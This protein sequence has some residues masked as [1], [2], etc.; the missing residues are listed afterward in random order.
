ME[1][2]ATNLINN[3]KKEALHKAKLQD[4]RT[5]NIDSYK[6]S[7]N[8]GRFYNAEEMM[9]IGTSNALIQVP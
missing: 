7:C 5:M 4:L 3:W 2:L 8:G 6:F 1:D 9:E